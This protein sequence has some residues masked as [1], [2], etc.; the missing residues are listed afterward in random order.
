MSLTEIENMPESR[1]R[2]W[3]YL[4]GEM[5]R[6]RKAARRKAKAVEKVRSNMQARRGGKR[7]RR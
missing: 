5:G 3:L 6:I 2:D 4:Q 1:R 7:K